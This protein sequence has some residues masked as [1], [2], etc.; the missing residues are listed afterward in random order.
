LFG[1]GPGRDHDQIDHP[2]HD[3]VSEDHGDNAL[4]SALF[5]QTLALLRLDEVGM[6]RFEVGFD[7]GGSVF[8]LC[9]GRIFSMRPL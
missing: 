5:T 6:L 2:G 1:G 4:D 3:H 7:A 8:K 9:Q